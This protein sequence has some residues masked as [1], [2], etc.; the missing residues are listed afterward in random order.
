MK[1]KKES[2]NGGHFFISLRERPGPA[3]KSDL[4]FSLS[5]Q[6]TSLRTIDSKLGSKSGRQYWLMVSEQLP[7]L[8]EELREGMV[9]EHGICHWKSRSVN[10][11]TV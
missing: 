5:V 4:E 1:G 7:V 8:C 3:K 10:K 9:A 6:E 11:D 2:K